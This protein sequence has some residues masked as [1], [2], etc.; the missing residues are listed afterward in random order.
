MVDAVQ[1]VILVVV[2]LLTMLLLV[3]G[4]QVFFIL[5][6]FRETMGRTNKILDDVESITDDV[7]EPIS[8]ISDFARGA[9][10]LSSIAKILQMLKK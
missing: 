8:V 1:I 9:R 10:G 3:L 4:V 5:K 7:K 6:E 2:I